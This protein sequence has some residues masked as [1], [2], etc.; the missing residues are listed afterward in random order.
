MSKDGEE[1]AR[2]LPGLAR[3]ARPAAAGGGRGGEPRR[4]SLTHL[5]TSR[6]RRLFGRGAW[7]G[8]AKPSRA[9]PPQVPVVQ[10]SPPPPPPPDADA[11]GADGAP[12]EPAAERS[13][14]PSPPRARS[15]SSSPA[16]PAAPPRAPPPPPRSMSSARAARVRAAL[17]APVADLEALRAL[18]WGGLPPG[19]RP[20]AWRLLLGYAPP[21]RERR[22]G[23]LARRR[24]E[25]RELLVPEYYEKTAAAAAAA[26]AV[27]E[28]EAAATA[29]GGAAGDANSYG[30]AGAP[31]ALLRA[32]PGGDD[33]A[34][35][36][37]VAVDVP[38]TAPGAPLFAA[39]RA[40]KVLERVLF[41]WGVRHPASGYVQGINDLATP[42]LAAFLGEALA[43]AAAGR[44]SS[45]AGGFNGAEAAADA[46]ANTDAAATADGAAAALLAL[47]LSSEA[48][49]AAALDALSETALLDAEA[50]AYWCLDALLAGVQDHYTAAQP[51]IQRCLFRAR[52][53]AAR[54]DAPLA[55]HLEA[56]GVEFVQVSGCRA[57]AAAGWSRARAGTVFSPPLFPLPSERI[58][59]A[60]PSSPSSP[61]P[62]TRSQFAFRWANCLLLRE[63]PFPL[64]ARLWDTLLAEGPAL[65]DFLPYALASFLLA[66]APA[67]RP[68]EFQELIMLLQ[69]PPTG[70]WGEADVEAVLARAHVWRASFGGAASHFA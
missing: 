5:P 39:P 12:A 34:S 26:A 49:V 4:A 61:R 69:R 28:A 19:E 30:A 60:S 58:S 51:G 18:A 25:Y 6:A 15:A 65:A 68:L 31:A 14:A 52:E 35:L 10:A 2:R 36:R 32:P 7:P 20:D 3:C 64:G 40:R 63:L 24:R 41:L 11:D 56:Q 13:G 21:A 23:A 29:R 57:M 48:A 47:D 17:A 42:F 1:S 66:W 33:E 54:V 70:A 37:Q 9:P 55:A 67:L 38:R 59:I 22:A 45:T 50:D 53:L 16:P 43:A 46:A 27:A 8:A 44:S 62:P